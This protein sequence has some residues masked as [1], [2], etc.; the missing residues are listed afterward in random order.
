M[1]KPTITLAEEIEP[2][3]IQRADISPMEGYL[4]RNTPWLPLRARMLTVLLIKR[5]AQ[6]PTNERL[7]ATQT[8][9]S[10]ACDFENKRRLRSPVLPAIRHKAQR[11]HISTVRL[12]QR[13]D[14]LAWKPNSYGLTLK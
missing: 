1:K 6:S 12:R 3:K 5:R 11:A 7:T 2:K 14:N 13:R 10:C 9:P 4:A 8:V